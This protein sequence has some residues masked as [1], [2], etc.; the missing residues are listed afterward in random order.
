MAVREI[1]PTVQVKLPAISNYHALAGTHFFNRQG[2][3]RLLPEDQLAKGADGRVTPNAPYEGNG[4]MPFPGMVGGQLTA[5]GLKLAQITDGTA[6]TA[7]FAETIEP[8][9]AA[10]L[11][12]QVTWMVATWPGTPDPPTPQP[13]PAP[14]Q[15]QLLGWSAEQLPKNFTSL[16]KQWSPDAKQPTPAYLPGNRWSGGKDR[17]WGPSSHHGT[18]VVHAFVDGHVQTLSVDIDKS[19]YLHLVT[20]GGRE[21]T[22]GGLVR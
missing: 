8:Q 3:G 22:Q 13:A 12:G 5:R 16:G 2:L 19:T 15:P 4:A 9:F 7:S 11:D 6:H 10:W 21:V 1:D 17:L 14:N 18:K 20:R